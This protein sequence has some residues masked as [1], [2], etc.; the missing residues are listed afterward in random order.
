MPEPTSKYLERH[1]DKAI[2][3]YDKGV[4]F[5]DFPEELKEVFN[6]WATAHEIRMKYLVKGEEFARNVFKAR[7]GLDDTTARQ[8]MRCCELFFGNIKQ[9]TRSYQR[10]LAQERLKR[11]AENA[12]AEGRYKEQAALE[13]ILQ[14][15]LDPIND[16]VSNIDWEELRQAVQP[17]IV[18]EPE[19]VDV[20]RMTNDEVEK[21][22]RSVMARIG[23]GEFEDAVII[24]SPKSPNDIET[25]NA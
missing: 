12:F 23:K 14:K 10:I 21:L 6:R 1:L 18:F 19:I 20:Q 3:L 25:E 16:P 24:D 5:Q 22:K 7:F 13:S 15:Y 8:D 4:P 11:A 9:S 2:R 17:T